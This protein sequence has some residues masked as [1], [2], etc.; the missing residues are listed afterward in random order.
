MSAA[1]NE[2]PKQRKPLRLWP[3]V[4]LVALTWVGRFVAPM[5]APEVPMIGLLVAVFG[6]LAVILWWLLFSRAW[7][8]ERLGALVLMFL[9]LVA[10]RPILDE[11]ISTAGMGVS[12]FMLAIPVLCLA[13][14]VWAVAARRLT[15]GPRWA[16]LVVALA[17]GGGIWGLLRTDGITGE[18]AQLLAFRWAATPEDRLLAAAGDEPTGSSSVELALL[19]G[20]EWPGFRGPDRIGVA[21]AA[22]IATDWAASP[23]VE[24]WR[25][26]IGPGWSSFAVHGDLLYT[27]EQRGENEL[28]SCYDAATGQQVWRHRDAV[29]FWESHAGA[30]PRATPALSGGRVYAF[31]ATGILNSLDARDGTIVWSRDAAADTGKAIPVWG[32]SSS[33][34]VAGDVVIVDTGTLVA[35]DLLTGEQRWS[36]P[37]SG[38][39]YS[40]PHAVILDGEPQVLLMTGGGVIGVAPADGT[41]LWEHKWPGAS[42]VQ[43]NLT[44]DGDVLIT[45]TGSSAGTAT[46][47]LAVNRDSGGWQV[48]ERWT[49]RG[50]KP[51]F[52]DFVVHEGH[53]YGFDG[54]ILS[55]ID[56]EDG[57]R[58]WKGGRYGH[59]QLVLL[60]EQ[61]LLLVVSERGELA[62]VTAKPDAFEELGRF[63]AVEGKSWAH[64]VLVGDL[65]LVRNAQEMAA[66]RLAAT[67]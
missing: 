65:V 4:V 27:Q 2:E 10:T 53:A 5:V 11:S 41:V 31:G 12:F 1:K 58:N 9:S 30:G 42:I 45:A 46:R 18:G 16:A 29:R 63:P 40:S 66:F 6:S 7:W 39:S 43:P 3:G 36:G 37:S 62:L 8:V 52:S 51:Y 22:R 25:R 35:Y 13:L 44:G 67:G 49:S 54:R 60:P 47:R 56:L 20:P 14:V 23:P 28:V 64:P 26:P 15:G 21:A 32:F 38:V 34:L 61:D 33:P 17:I 55:S 57:G 59:G 19:T 24:L 48:E 50:L